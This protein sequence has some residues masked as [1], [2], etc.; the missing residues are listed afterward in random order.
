M[1][2]AIEKKQFNISNGAAIAVIIFLSTVMFGAGS[3]FNSFIENQKT[4][5][6]LVLKLSI[7]DSINDLQTKANTNN[8]A[9]LKFS[10]DSANKE[11]EELASKW[12]NH[13]PEK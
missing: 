7:R 9:L 8:I 5:Y 10:R 11:A 3:Y 4:T 1:T 6:S 13:R 12:A 2:L